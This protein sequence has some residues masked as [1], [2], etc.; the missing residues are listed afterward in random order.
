MRAW[1]IGASALV[2]AG[3]AFAF[4]AAVQNAAPLPK[5]SGLPFWAQD[6]RCLLYTTEEGTETKAGQ[7]DVE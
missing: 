2:L 6:Q 3:G 5:A 7:R 1:M 4:P